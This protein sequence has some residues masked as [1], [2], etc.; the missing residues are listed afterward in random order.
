MGDD[1]DGGGSTAGG[2]RKMTDSISDMLLQE[3]HA[4]G[5]GVVSLMIDY[6]LRNETKEH[7]LLLDKVRGD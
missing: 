5:Q 1:D 7:L 6:A 2:E 4:R 3:A